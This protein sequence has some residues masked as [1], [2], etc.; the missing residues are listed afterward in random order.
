MPIY[1]FE[2]K[3]CGYRFEMLTTMS[4]AS[5]TQQCPSCGK[6]SSERLISAS[7]VSVSSGSQSCG[8]RGFG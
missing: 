8:P 7:S 1:E 4:E 2:C 3:K 5:K 6:K